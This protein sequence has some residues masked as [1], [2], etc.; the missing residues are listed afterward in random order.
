M[1]INMMP[2]ILI[3]LPLSVALLTGIAVA[4]ARRQRHP[5]I[6]LLASL[7]FGLLL[8]TSIGSAYL[9]AK[10]PAL[11]WS[12]GLQ[13]HQY[14]PVLFVSGVVRFLIDALAIGLLIAAV[15]SGRDTNRR[16]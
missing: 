6:S 4:V 15:F 7:S 1:T 14:G 3:M 13:P 8:L 10:L 11:L 12:K 5:R 16:S 9:N 2:T